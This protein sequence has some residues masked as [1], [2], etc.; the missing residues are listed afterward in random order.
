MALKK[1]TTLPETERRFIDCAHA[2]HC[3]HSSIIRERLKTGWANLCWQHYA[4]HV[5]RERT[6]K[7]IAAGKPTREQSLEKMK[8]LY[9]KTVIGG[10]EP[11]CD[12]ELQEARQVS[13]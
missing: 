2:P 12:D 3:G 10:R 11:G 5:E 4:E 8:G 1:G 9:I 13:A 7:W 6:A